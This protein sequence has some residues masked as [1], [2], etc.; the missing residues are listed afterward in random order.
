[1]LSN[2]ACLMRLS[3]DGGSSSLDYLLDVIQPHQILFGFGEN[4]QVHVH[5]NNPS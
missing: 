3:V 4:H 2:Q 1:M 5:A